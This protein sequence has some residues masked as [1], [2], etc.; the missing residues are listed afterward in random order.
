MEEEMPAFGRKLPREYRGHTASM[1]PVGR[2]VSLL[3]VRMACHSARLLATNKLSCLRS[4][5]ERP[6]WDLPVAARGLS[7]MRCSKSAPRG[8]ADLLYTPK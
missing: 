8:T 6:G 5:T 7:L 2:S 4:G 1:P 3:L